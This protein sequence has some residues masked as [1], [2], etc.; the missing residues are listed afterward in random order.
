LVPDA[1]VQAYHIYFPDPWPKRRHHRRRLLTRD[2]VADLH[3][4]LRTAGR[5]NIAT[6]FEEYFIQIQRVMAGTSEFRERQPV[7]LPEEARTDFEREFLAAGR[8]IFRCCWE[9]T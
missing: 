9:K 1:S 6:D 5:V 2:F 8:R 7:A 4:T 3:R